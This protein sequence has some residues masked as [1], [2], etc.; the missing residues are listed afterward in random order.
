LKAK[1]PLRR[2]RMACNQDSAKRVARKYALV[3]INYGVGSILRWKK[4]LRMFNWKDIRQNSKS[5]FSQIQNEA[6]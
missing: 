3:S 2:E 5:T 6:F 1:W 4:E